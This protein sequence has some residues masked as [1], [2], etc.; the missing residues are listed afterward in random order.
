VAYASRGLSKS[1]ANYPAHKLEFL[2]LKWAVTEK[3]ADYVYGAHFTILTDN[4]PLTYILTTAKLDATGQ[5]WLAALVNYDF[6]IKYK[7]GKNNQ[8]ADGLSRRPQEPPYEDEDYIHLQDQIG[9]MRARFLGKPLETLTLASLA[10]TPACQASSI[11]PPTFAAI[12]ASHGIKHTIATCASTVST[13]PNETTERVDHDDD[14]EDDPL[15]ESISDSPEVIPGQ[16]VDSSLGQ[17]SLPGIDLQEWRRLQEGDINIAPV[18]KSLSIGKKPSRTW[19]ADQPNE[20]KLLFRQ[21]DKLTI[22]VVCYTGEQ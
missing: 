17:N 12:C 4:N 8:D 22:N 11:D 9:K 5:R 3:F 16:F 13:D 7:P 10:A 6:D 14:V 20:T 1:E 15:V 21:W 19:V 18:M 2:A